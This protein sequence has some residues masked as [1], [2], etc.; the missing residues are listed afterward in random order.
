MRYVPCGDAR[1][2]SLGYRAPRRRRW[3]HRVRRALLAF[4][5]LFLVGCGTISANMDRYHRCQAEVGERPEYP[6]AGTFGAMGGIYIG[7]QPEFKAWAAKMDACTAR[8]RALDAH[9][10]R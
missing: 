2:P 4:L 5:P 8:Q 7:Q 6:A 10:D 3:R 1:G 9:T